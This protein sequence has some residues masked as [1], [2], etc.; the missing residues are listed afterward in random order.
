MK[1]YP[2]PLPASELWELCNPN[3]SHDF[4]KPFE[5][6]NGQ[7]GISNGSLAIRLSS[8]IDPDFV[9]HN[10][11]AATRLDAIPWGVLDEEQTEANK[12]QWKLTDER[13][14]GLHSRGY[15]DAWRPAPDSS[16]LPFLRVTT[17]RV[18]VGRAALL[19]SIPQFQLVCKLPRS[20]FF[21]GDPGNRFLYFR[22]NGGDGVLAEEPTGLHQQP[23][24]G[25]KQI[26]DIFRPRQ[27]SHFVG[28]LL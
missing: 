18:C 7:V 26:Y 12:R 6:E 11:K 22:F 9:S 23:K 10:P 8:F 2:Y 20:E 14:A 13:R 16:T 24:D 21:I 27:E 1:H 25:I 3:K 4:H 17:P 15:L 19:I 28:G 5:L